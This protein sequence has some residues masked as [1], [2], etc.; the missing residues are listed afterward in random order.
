MNIL[1]TGGAGFLGQQ[2][3]RTLLARGTLEMDGVE[4]PISRIVCFDQV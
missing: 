4:H 2:L 1:I 3:I